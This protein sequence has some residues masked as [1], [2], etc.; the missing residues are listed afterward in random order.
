[1]PLVAVG[2]KPQLG[3]PESKI[4]VELET[5]LTDPVGVLWLGGELSVT[6]AVHVV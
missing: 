1:M 4:P 5:K 6:V 3:V 2:D